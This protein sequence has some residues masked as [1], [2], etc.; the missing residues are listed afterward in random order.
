MANSTLHVSIKDIAKVFS[1]ML[2]LTLPLQVH[3]FVFLL[4]LVA[5]EDSKPMKSSD[6]MSSLV[7]NTAVAELP[8]GT[9]YAVLQA[10]GGSVGLH[11]KH[12]RLEGNWKVNSGKQTCVTWN[13]PS[14]PTTNCAKM[15]DLGEGKYQ[16][17]E[18]SFVVKPGD[19]KNLNK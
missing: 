17:G 19:V 1:F 11:P 6:I 7:D 2:I 9:A 3:A 10:D 5:G 18:K 12:G 15:F 16:W 14:G 13:Y 4:P 8:E